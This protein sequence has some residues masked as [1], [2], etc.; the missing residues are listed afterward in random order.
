M[1]FGCNFS[2]NSLGLNGLVYLFLNGLRVH[3]RFEWF[4]IKAKKP[5]HAHCYG[6]GPSCFSIFVSSIS[7]THTLTICSVKNS[8]QN[9]NGLLFHVG[10]VWTGYANFTYFH[11]CILMNSSSTRHKRYWKFGKYG[12]NIKR[13]SYF[14]IINPPHRREQWEE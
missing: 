4:G 1:Q 10:N 8:A 5:T 14:F 7:H 13:N 11:S 2:L 6:T 9:Y 3:K 12:K